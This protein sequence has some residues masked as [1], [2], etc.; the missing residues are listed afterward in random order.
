MATQETLRRS[1]VIS[2]MRFG[3]DRDD[4]GLESA[5]GATLEPVAARGL[6]ELLG[7]FTK[8]DACRQR[9]FAFCGGKRLSR[10]L[11]AL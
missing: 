2:N 7:R 10:E 5:Y 3:A 1:L 11:H 4:V 9:V 6:A 8:G